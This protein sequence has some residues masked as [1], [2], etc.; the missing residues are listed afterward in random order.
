MNSNDS[1]STVWPG[2]VAAVS[3]LVLSLLLLAGVLVVAISQTSRVLEAYN[4]QLIEAVLAEELRIR[5]IQAKS[6][7]GAAEPAPNPVVS[8]KVAE[9]APQVPVMQATVGL[10]RAE[11]SGASSKL[12]AP[13]SGAS[14]REMQ[15]VLK[16]LDQRIDDQSI[17]IARLQAD[18]SRLAQQAQRP[19][20]PPSRPPSPQVY[21]L[22][23]SPGA[24]G[25]DAFLLS[26]LKQQLR[27]EAGSGLPSR[28]SLESGV[29][30]LDRVAERE[31]FR[32]VL[33]VR[34]QLQEL[35]I[36]SEQ[37]TVLLHRELSSEAVAGRPA[38]LK[39]G[40]LVLVLRRAGTAAKGA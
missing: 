34:S 14:T 29:R 3:S 8:S 15:G 17:E 28:W 21:R 24:E 4:R 27:S 10:E 33:R 23:F 38:G 5:G 35:G 25:M 37:V 39:P 2:Y 16:S 6:S 20:D 30:G 7:G 18:L 9:A 32:L 31:V 40:D 1:S 22:M 19:P 36:P 13:T 11:D 26:E 12:V